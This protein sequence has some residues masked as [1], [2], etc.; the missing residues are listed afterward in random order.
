MR[1][2]SP[3]LLSGRSVW[4]Q[5]FFPRDEFEERIRKVRT[6]A[7][8]Q[9]IDG[10]LLFGNRTDY[11]NLVYLT[12]FLP[13]SGWA[14]AILPLTGDS[15]STLFFSGGGARDAPF[16]RTITWIEDVRYL[17]PVDGIG[18]ILDE[19][20]PRMKRLGI[21][22]AHAMPVQIHEGLFKSLSGHDLAEVDHLLR[23]IRSRLRPRERS[24][25]V[26]A[27]SLVQ[28]A[29]EKASECFL[30]GESTRTA[31]VQAELTARK[32]GAHDFRISINSKDGRWLWPL[33]NSVQTLSHRLVAYMAV[34]FQGY[35]ADGTVTL[36]LPDSDVGKKAKRALDSMIDAARP[37]T[38]AGAVADCALKE[39]GP[40]LGSP[41]TEIGLGNGLGLSLEEPPVVRI[42]AEDQLIE[43]N[44][45][46]LRVYIP[47]GENSVFFSDL[48]TIG[49]EGGELFSM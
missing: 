16:M 10:L 4:D 11:A 9:G 32:Q 44:I 48:I 28:L 12:H 39:L 17:N 15:D 26:Q 31:L 13:R 20:Y 8:E 25:I 14:I 21:I 42:G 24:A 1:T 6:L 30:R 36:P 29:R 45:L 5:S 38:T 22:G 35:W 3:V 33:D 27:W 19:K 23:E 49:K 41:A 2:M 43:G 34:E 47:D 37:G 7:A 18:T 40:E 46:S